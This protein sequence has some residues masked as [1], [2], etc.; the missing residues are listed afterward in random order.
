MLSDG[1]NQLMDAVTG[2]WFDFVVVIVTINVLRLEQ[3]KGDDIVLR[4][5]GLHRELHLV[6]KANDCIFRYIRSTD[7]GVERLANH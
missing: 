4:F 3:D 6:R 5:N 7:K 1:A 2:H